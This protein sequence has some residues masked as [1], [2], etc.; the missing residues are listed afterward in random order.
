MKESK[1]A[2]GAVVNCHNEWD[3]LEEIIVGTLDGAV[4]LPWEIALHAVTPADDVERARSFALQHGSQ[5]I[6]QFTSAPAQKELDEFVNI[7]KGEGVKVRRPDHVNHERPI[8]TPEWTSA[9]GNCHA[10]PRDVLII[11]GNEIIEAPMAWR[12]RYFEFF[13]Y[14]SLVKDYWKKGAKWTAAPKPTMSHRLYN[15]EYK[16]GEEYVTTEFEPVWDAADMARCGRD[17]FIQRSHVT[18]DAGI[19]WIQRHLGDDYTLHKVEFA[20]DRAIHIDATFVPL[21]PGKVMVNPDRPI[22][23]MP[24]IITKGGWDVLT[25][26]ASTMSESHPH[27]RSFKWLSMNM[28]NLDEERVIVESSEEPMIKQLKDWGFKPIPCNFRKCYRYGGSFH[29]ATVDVRRRGE[30]QSY[31]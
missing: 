3:P 20:D 21:A 26:P 13:A 19:E 25:P 22:K 1:G 16:R 27:Y 17:I 29:C 8:S 2:A 23:E 9:G 10:N 24:E 31:F 15:Y 7:L 5:P 6:A 28:L 14:R 11:I 18:N 30:L 4:N 12:S